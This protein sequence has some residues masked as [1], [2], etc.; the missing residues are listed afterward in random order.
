MVQTVIG[1]FDSSRQVQQAVQQLYDSG[2]SDKDVDVSV[3]SASEYETD[4]YQS[5]EENKEDGIGERIARF[6]RSLFDSEEDSRKYAT[7]ARRG[8]VV[9]V[10]ARSQEEAQR[11]S[12]ILDAFGA[13]DV[14]ERVREYEGELHEH[15]AE[16]SRGENRSY[17]NE[18][19]SRSIPV[20]EE[21]FQVGKREVQSGGVRIRS[22]I[23]ER[24]VEE[25]LRLR[26]EF[27]NVERNPVNRPAN[28]SDLSTFKEEEIEMKQTAEIPVV[29][30]EARVVEEINLKK[31]VRERDEVIKDTVKRKDVEVEDLDADT[32]ASTSST[33]KNRNPNRDKE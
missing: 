29:K 17:S 27:V 5:R 31:D 23:I 32:D 9:T 6:F 8:T 18:G 1:I 12:E 30:K 19:R 28:E 24:P 15:E 10:Q 20:I 7:V 4:E 26:E 13:I 11:A 2:F 16:S 14:D 21:D 22:R 3:H 33:K 25:S